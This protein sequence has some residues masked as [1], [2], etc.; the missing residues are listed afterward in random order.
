M[1]IHLILWAANKVNPKL[2]GFATIYLDCLGALGKVADLPTNR[3]PFRCHH[4]DILKNIMINC[5]ELTFALSYHHVQAHQDNDTLYHLL[6]HPLQLNCVCDIHAKHVICC[7]NG[8]KLPH[9]EVFPLEP[10]T[11]FVVEKMTSD[12]SEEIRLWAHRKLA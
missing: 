6:L 11:V 3:I 1:T 8:D 5:S 12:T 2:T 7:I 9:Q 4:S 10:V